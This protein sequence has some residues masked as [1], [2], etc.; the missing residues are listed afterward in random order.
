MLDCRL[1]TRLAPLVAV[2]A[3]VPRAAG[4]DLLEWKS[5]D[6]KL[7]AAGYIQID[8]RAFPGWDVAEPTLRNH[9][10][11]V[12]RLRAG[13]EFAKGNLKGEVIL[14]GNDL[15]RSVLHPDDSGSAFAIRRNLSNAYLEQDLGRGFF[16]RVGHFKVPVAREFL[17]SAAATDFVERSLLAS[18]MAPSRDWGAM[19]GGKL[20]V[21][22]SLRYQLGLFAGDGWGDEETRSDTTGAGRLL[23][24]ATKGLELGVSASLGRV[25]ADPEDPVVSPNPKSLRGKSASG[26]S[27]FHRVHVD[28]QRRRLGADL[29][30]A[31][32]P[33]TLKGEVLQGRD[34]RKG[35]GAIGDDLPAVS[36]F[37]WAASALVRVV[38]VG[39][40]KGKGE[41]PSTLDLAVRYEALKFDDEGPDEGFAGA[42]N[43]ARNL[44]PQE[45]RALSGGVNYR[46]R[47]WARL[48]GDVI[49]ERY[50]DDLLAPETGRKGNYVT[51]LGRLQIELP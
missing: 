23:L 46:A 15:A 8:G 50:N 14:D 5:G 29:T 26:W 38:G 32:G 43:R 20:K 25:S 30:Y 31:R 49:L 16:V 27:F 44:R 22:R 45:G 36:G 40:K 6:F 47:P 10:V 13:L 28:G 18:G 3:L 35:Q 12:R 4:A 34:E 9:S 42:G 21:A 11:D 2:A 37:G 19:V 24:E 1:V 39:A 17:T 7:K 51:I 33:L 41:T 48:M